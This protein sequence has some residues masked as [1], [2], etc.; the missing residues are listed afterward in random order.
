MSSPQ[1]TTKLEEALEHNKGKP[2]LSSQGHSSPLLWQR[3]LEVIN[4][5]EQHWQGGSGEG[6]T[7]QAKQLLRRARLLAC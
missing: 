4:G 1:D 3:G 7:P 2:Q 6:A 5:G